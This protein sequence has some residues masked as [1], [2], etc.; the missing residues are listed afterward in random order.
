MQFI[1]STY[2]SRQCVGFRDL[3]L[4]EYVKG[5]ASH[6]AFPSF[7]SVLSQFACD[8]QP[9]PYEK[10]KYVQCSR[11]STRQYFASVHFRQIEANLNTSIGANRKYRV[12]HPLIVQGVGKTTCLS[13]MP[14]LHLQAT[15]ADG[16]CPGLP[17]M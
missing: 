16:L 2:E 8:L 1:N 12:Q 6:H 11:R 7:E 15:Q 17:V 4:I 3:S 10:A 5:V 9:R 13:L 14:W